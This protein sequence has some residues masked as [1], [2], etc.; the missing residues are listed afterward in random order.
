MLVNSLIVIPFSEFGTKTRASREKMMDQLHTNIKHVLKNIFSVEWTKFRRFNE[1]LVYQFR[2]HD[3]PIALD[4][5][6]HVPG[7][8][9]VHVCIET[10]T[11][12]KI[13]GKKLQ[14]IMNSAHYQISFKNTKIQLLNFK[15]KGEKKKLLEDIN[16]ELKRIATLHQDLEDD[17]NGLHLEVFPDFTYISLEAHEGMDG[18]PVGTQNPLVAEIIGRPSDLLASLLSLKRGVVI[19]PIFFNIGNLALDTNQYKLFGEFCKRVLETFHGFPVKKVFTI[20]L[21]EIL[22]SLFKKDKNLETRHPCGTCII[23]RRF[24]MNKAIQNLGLKTFIIQGATACDDSIQ[25]CPFNDIMNPRLNFYNN[26]FLNPL[27]FKNIQIP[28]IFERYMRSSPV[29]FDK[30]SSYSWNLCKLKQNEGEDVLSSNKINA[31]NSTL[32]ALDITLSSW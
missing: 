8:K 4:G 14:N 24:I 28:E 2:E 32:D 15:N 1:R 22:T 5:L 11:D 6:K 18:N 29:K 7:I 16:A 17:Q 19:T 30:T 27:M 10:Q 9:R 31:I 20:P 21:D 23:T 3:L 25:S 12:V 13:V 26:F